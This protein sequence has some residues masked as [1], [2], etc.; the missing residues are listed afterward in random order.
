MKFFID[1]ILLFVLILISGGMLV[2][3]GLQRRGAKVSILQATQMFNQGKT[4][5]LDVRAEEEFAK[6]HLRDAKN[7]PIK[8]LASR[9]GEIDKFKA[10]AVVVLCASGVQSSKASSLLKNAGFNDVHILD[11]GMTAW[12]TQGL[13]TVK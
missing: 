2:W 11:G 4:L 8:Q 7:I 6:G 3:P 13:P 5:M 1:N 9:V 12:Q 10:K